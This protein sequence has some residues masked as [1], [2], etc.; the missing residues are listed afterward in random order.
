M[1]NIVG[2]LGILLML[3]GCAAINDLS[4]YSISENELRSSLD[5]HVSELKREVSLAGIPLKL[6]VSEMDIKVGP[7]NR[8]VVMLQTK[9]TATVKAFG[10]T[11]PADVNLQIEGQP[12]YD[13]EKKAIFVRSLRLLDSTIEANGYRGNLAPVSDKFMS[14]FNGY[15]ATHPVY[16]LDTRS[17]LMNM[18]ASMPLT[19]AIEPGKLV[20]RQQE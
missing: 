13:A 15:L 18:A 14:L 1:K 4:S 20:I 2:M 7:D 9:A 8:Q 17:T 6:D 10:F 11:Y 12:F 5:D 19:L 16:E 3:S